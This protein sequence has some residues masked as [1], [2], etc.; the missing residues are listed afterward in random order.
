MILNECPTMMKKWC[1]RYKAGGLI[2]FRIQ[3]MEV[4]RKAFA[5]ETIMP[6]RIFPCLEYLLEF[7]L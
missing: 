7:Y 3:V 5:G 6:A 2:S 4:I 1:W